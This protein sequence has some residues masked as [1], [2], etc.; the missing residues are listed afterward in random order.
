MSKSR[1][2]GTVSRSA[3]TGQFVTPAAARRNPGGT[4]TE[5]KAGQGGNPAY[6]SAETGRYVT[7]ATARRHPGSTVAEDQK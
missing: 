5:S 7:E 6:R 4:V 3:K 1:S 2:R